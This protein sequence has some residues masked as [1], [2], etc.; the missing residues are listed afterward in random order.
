MMM[1]DSRDKAGFSLVELAIVILLLVMLIPVAKYLK[2]DSALQHRA[3]YA[4]QQTTPVRDMIAAFHGQHQRWPT[5][6]ELGVGEYIPYPEGGG[7]RLR[8]DGSIAITF[9]TVDELRGKSIYII[10][11]VSKD[12]AAMSWTCL[13]DPEIPAHFYSGCY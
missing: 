11:V 12:G 8:A 10:P 1:L 7:Y 6:A 2:R 9:A 3:I 13:A 5:P 4:V